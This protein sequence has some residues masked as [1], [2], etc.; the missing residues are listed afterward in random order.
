MKVDVDDHGAVDVVA[1]T[2]ATAARSVARSSLPAWP[3]SGHARSSSCARTFWATTPRLLSAAEITST[4]IGRLTP[5]MIRSC[6]SR[7][8]SG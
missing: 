6:P 1:P 3:G 4:I 2:S 5:V 7:E 8:R